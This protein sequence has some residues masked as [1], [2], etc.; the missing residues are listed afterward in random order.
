MASLILRSMSFGLA[1]MSV[2]GTL[3][4]APKA[5]EAVTP[6][7]ARAVAKD[8]YIYG[9]PMVDGYRIQYAALRW[10]RRVRNSKHPGIS[11]TTPLGYLLPR[12]RL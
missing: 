6:A 1:A 7:E 12:T 5:T 4:A 11:S 9:F 3:F 2:A 10:T 8:A